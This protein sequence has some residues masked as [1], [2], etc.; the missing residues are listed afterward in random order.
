MH[1]FLKELIRL[2]LLVAT[3]FCIYD[4]EREWSLSSHKVQIHLYVLILEITEIN[5]NVL[6][7]ISIKYEVAWIKNKEEHKYMEVALKYSSRLHVE[8]KM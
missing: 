5:H 6:Y 7:A 8:S 1:Y 2:W 4:L 3:F